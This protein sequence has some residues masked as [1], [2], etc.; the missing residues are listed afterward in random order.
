[1]VSGQAE[2]PTAEFLRLHRS[3]AAAR[4]ARA[5]TDGMQAARPRQAAPQARPAARR[6]GEHAGRGR[7]RVRRQP[8][9]RRC[10]GCRRSSAASGRL[11]FTESSF[12]LHD[13]RGRL[14]GGAVA[15]LGRHARRTRHRGAR[16]RRRL[17]RGR[18]HA[19]RACPA[20]PPAA[21]HLSGSFGYIV[22]VRGAGRR[23]A[24]DASSRRCAASR[25]RCRRRW[26]RAPPR[27]CRC[28]SR[29]LRRRRRARPRLGRARH[30]RPCRAAAAPAGRRDGR[31]A[32]RG[33]AQPR[34]ATGDPPAGA[35]RHA[36][37][38]LARRVRP[39]PLA[40]APCRRRA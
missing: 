33:V 9:H 18:A 39:R 24:R 20:R 13:V 21:Q 5:F 2:G 22:T 34:R 35:A 28:A 37:V 36:G 10:R 26:R 8:G 1:M 12:T 11:A 6:A 3:L 25:A 15:H 40:A 17:G 7:L 29:S 31:A 23:R 30:A 4:D 27:R 16:A 38:R 32:H 19:A 14:L